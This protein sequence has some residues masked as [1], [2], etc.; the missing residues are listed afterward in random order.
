MQNHPLSLKL[1]WTGNPFPTLSIF[2]V[3]LA[4][5]RGSIFVFYPAALSVSCVYGSKMTAPALVLFRK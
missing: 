3:L 5:F 4:L 2:F 1:W